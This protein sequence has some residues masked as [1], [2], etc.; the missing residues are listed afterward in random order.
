LEE[1]AEVYARALFEAAKDHDALD[2]VHEQLGQFADAL[3][4]S[5]DLMQFFFSPYF[6]VD[7]KKDALHRAVNEADAI[8]MNFLEAL[9][10]RHRMPVIFRI[11][12]RF[13]QLWEEEH[14]LLPVEVTS[15]VA[16]DERTVSGIGESI[17]KQLG[18]TIEL[19]SSVD[20]EIIGGVVLRV[21]N[22]VLDASIRNRL[23]KLRQQVARA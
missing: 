10:E 18:R 19:S 2:Q 7:E 22:F 3:N 15:A 8:F 5:R 13:E 20:P 11:Q 1:V 21:G 14:R 6:S 23:E 17:G 16:L 12:A 9:L 4:N